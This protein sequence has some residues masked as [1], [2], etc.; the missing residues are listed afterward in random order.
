MRKYALIML[1]MVT[2][3][4][5]LTTGSVGLSALIV[6]AVLSA[7]CVGIIRWF[8][9]E[10]DFLIDIFL[11]ALAVRL[12]FGLFLHVFSLREFFG[13]DALTFDIYGNQII[14]V[15]S[16]RAPADDMVSVRAMSTGTPGWGIHYLT[17]LVYAVFGRNILAAQ[18]FIV[19]IGAA[20]A[21]MV[22]YCAHQMFRNNRVSKVSALLVA[23]FPAFVVW[24]SQLLKD[25]VIIFLLVLAMTMVLRLQA[26]LDY[27]AVAVLVVALFG[28]ISFRFYIF[29]MVAVAVAGSLI[30]GREGS[31][32]SLVRGVILLVLVGL[33]LTYVGV[34][35]TA[36][37]NLDKFGNLEAVQRSRADLAKSAESG[38]GEDTDVSTAEGA[39]STIPTG[40]TYL[41]FAPFPWAA[42]SLR[43]SITIPETLVWWA[44]IPFLISGLL[45]TVKNKLRPALPVL[46]FALMLTFAYSIFQGNVGT[47]YRQRTQIQ[48]F[49]FIFIGVGYTVMKEKRENMLAERR[50]RQQRVEAR[51]RS[52]RA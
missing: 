33:A 25:G 5:L 36:T 15:W 27:R 44:M 22:Y 9:F 2:V 4:Y 49:L 11:L 51:L 19:V 50:A 46:V 20:T 28:I 7:V 16:G 12:A 38:F 23:L 13:G 29:Y 18:T 26:K 40:L 39:L 17:A 34:L 24:S 21:P 10:A 32:R 48:V 6:A 1:A 3:S 45:Y 14:E 31:V 47:A 35:Q 37:E 41:M 30:I 8:K 42:S 52:L 43:Q